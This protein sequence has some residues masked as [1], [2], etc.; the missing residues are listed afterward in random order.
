MI[1]KDIAKEA[2][3]SISTV[4]RVIN[5]KEQGAASK[6]TRDK[7]WSIVRKNGYTP[8]VLAQNLKRRTS[9]T[10]PKEKPLYYIDC[11]QARTSNL[12]TDPFF[13]ELERA[14]EQEAFNYNYIIKHTYLPMDLK[15]LDSIIQADERNICGLVIL[16]RYMFTKEQ[17]KVLKEVYKNIIY[18]GLNAIP[19]KC[20]QVICD[21]Y[22]AGISAVEYLIELGHKK[23]AYIGEQA[24]ECR[25]LA[26][27]DALS[28]HN[29]TFTIHN[30]ANVI[31]STD[32][33]YK[34]AQKLL[35]SSSD[36][37][38]VFCAN[39]LTA[40]GAIKAFHEN[41]KQVSRDISV[42]SVDDIDL[43][44]YITPM[45]T[46][47]HIPIEELGRQTART[48][49]DRINGRHTLPMKVELPFFIAKRDS[50]SKCRTTNRQQ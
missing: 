11:L 38:A 45:L 23:I 8:N 27:K 13:S 43:A 4:S 41:K 33:G 14:L 15:S 5:G 28:L 36:F 3:V 34:G 25:F 16:G 31:Q 50:C 19:L 49:I 29:I 42:I 6:E 2:G 21:G 17:L 47:V 37:T 24:N 26:Y 48:L 35:N 22:K 10:D 20:D 39:D 46:T 44:Q 9:L 32:G 30:T 40:I 1:L 12:N 18:V 7:I